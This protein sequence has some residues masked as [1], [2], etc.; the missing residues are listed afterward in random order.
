MF[1]DEK[2]YYGKKT[3]WEMEVEVVLCVFIVKF[4]AFVY[5]SKTKEVCKNLEI[6]FVILHPSQLFVVK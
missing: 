1:R 3:N 4:K 6:V 2:M 5:N